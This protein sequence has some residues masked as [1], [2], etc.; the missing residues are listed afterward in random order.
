METVDS[1]GIAAD[2]ATIMA[3]DDVDV[4]QCEVTELPDVLGD[5]AALLD[6]REPDEWQGGHAPGAQHIPLGEVPA[7]L[8]EID[9]TKE[10]FV[11]CHFGGRSQRV[12][13]YLV[14]NGFDAVNV[15]GGMAARA[16]AGRPVVTDDGAPGSI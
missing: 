13:Q 5:T 15:V 7:R 4:P 11:I 14:R 9:T 16:A 8:A 6:V 2:R 1:V 3:M 10:L 12:A